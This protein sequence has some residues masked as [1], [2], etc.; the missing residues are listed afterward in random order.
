MGKTTILV[1]PKR[2]LIKVTVSEWNELFSIWVTRHDGSRIQ[3]FT[4]V[5]EEHG[6]ERRFR[7]NVSVGT[8]VAIGDSVNGILKGDIA[9]IDYVV[10]GGDD[11]FVGIHNGSRMVAIRAN[12]TYHEKNSSPMLDGRLAWKK[13]DFDFLGT[14]LGVVRMGKVKAIRPYV[15][16]KYENPKRL[17][18]SEAGIREVSDEIVERE[19]ISAH[20]DSGF[21]DGD[22]VLVK[23]AD[24]VS[25]WIDK[26]EISV[27]FENDILVRL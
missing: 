23:E 18:V 22:K 7:Q 1:H 16:L 13:G 25:R 21:V 26:K 6:Y 14:L 4:D 20:P 5:E 9:I 27:V 11:A 24:L 10:T 17:E 12:S 19:V 15:F 8:I 2:V 3:L